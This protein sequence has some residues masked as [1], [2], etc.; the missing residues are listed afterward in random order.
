MHPARRVSP[1]VQA[2]WHVDAIWNAI[3]EHAKKC[4]ECKINFNASGREKFMPAPT[5]EWGQALAEELRIAVERREEN[6]AR[7]G[8]AQPTQGVNHE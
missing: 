6:T 1:Y 5:C 4:S 2:A 8:P 7:G 3:A